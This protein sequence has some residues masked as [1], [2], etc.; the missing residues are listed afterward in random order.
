ME[1]EWIGE[2]RQW[3]QALVLLLAETE[4]QRGREEGKKK[5]KERKKAMM[6]KKKLVSLIQLDWCFGI[7]RLKSDVGSV[8]CC[9]KFW[10]MSL[11]FRSCALGTAFHR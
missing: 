10:Y 5:M 9:C 2:G 3:R 1:W 4:G 11:C 7:N 6:A 8:L